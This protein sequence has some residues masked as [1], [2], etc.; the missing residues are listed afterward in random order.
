MPGRAP[1]SARSPG[2]SRAVRPTEHAGR[3]AEAQGRASAQREMAYSMALTV[4]NLL[5]ARIEGGIR[6]LRQPVLGRDSAAALPRL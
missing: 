5:P 1:E 6:R 2:A 3:L 4:R